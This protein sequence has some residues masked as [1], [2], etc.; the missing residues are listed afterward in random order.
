[1]RQMGP[2]YR[3]LSP[4]SFRTFEDSSLKVSSVQSL[5]NFVASIL[6]RAGWRAVVRRGAREAGR[7]ELDVDQRRR[8]AAAAVVQPGPADVAF[9]R[10]QPVTDRHDCSIW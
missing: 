5:K 6:I 9:R 2:F 1:M 10:E 3:N 8:E 7:A 4:Q